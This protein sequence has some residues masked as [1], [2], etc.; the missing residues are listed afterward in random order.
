MDEFKA[1]S[2]ELALNGEDWIF[3]PP[4]TV[5]QKHLSLTIIY[6]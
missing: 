5:K 1:A 4:Q 2:I 6:Y 3:N